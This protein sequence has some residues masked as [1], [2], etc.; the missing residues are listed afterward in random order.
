MNR[1]PATF[2]CSFGNFYC[3]YPEYLPGSSIKLFHNG[4]SRWA[5]LRFGAHPVERA[6][7]SS[8]LK[9]MKKKLLT[10]LSAVAVVSRWKLRMY[11]GCFWSSVIK[12]TSTQDQLSVRNVPLSV[13]CSLAEVRTIADSCSSL[14]ADLV[15]HMCPLR[16]WNGRSSYYCVPTGESVR[17]KYLLR[18]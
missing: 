5:E 1:R 16:A 14:L 3:L 4:V 2:F 11:T 8:L 13:I 15:L 18:Q 7:F 17:L 10:E 9:I 12:T 6:G